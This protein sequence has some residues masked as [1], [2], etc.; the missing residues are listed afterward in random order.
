V[1]G[2]RLLQDSPKA[3]ARRVH[4]YWGVWRKQEQGVAQTNGPG[5]KDIS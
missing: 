4:G 3:F 5:A 2:H 1:L